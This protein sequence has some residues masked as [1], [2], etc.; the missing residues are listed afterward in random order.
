MKKAV[1]ITGASSGIGAA[2]AKLFSQH[3]YFAYLLGRNEEHLT[4]VAIQC[5]H[6][7]SLLR[8]DLNSE[9][10]VIKYTQH[11][12][13]RPDTDLQILINNAGIFERT[14]HTSDGGSLSTWRKQFD[15]NLFSAINIT[16]KILPLFMQKKK[17]S[18]VNV[19]ST[20]GLKPSADTAAY[21]AS[22]AAMINWTQSLAQEL[23]PLQIRVNC[24]APGIV[25]TPIHSFHHLKTEDKQNVLNQLSPLQPL[26][27]IGNVDE[28]AQAIYFLGSEQSSWTTGAVL[29]VDGGIN[30]V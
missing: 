14:N 21:S 24:V 19:S 22:K 1:L 11:L 3:G 13:E 2:T 28:I 18:I 29:A 15:T 8:C 23:G 27:R 20:L 10:S 16:E 26:Q 17:G 9:A 7:A 12:F 4:E 25:D 5:Q 6:G 30:L